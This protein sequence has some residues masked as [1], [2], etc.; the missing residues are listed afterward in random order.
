ML[1][2]LETNEQSFFWSRMT[3]FV[4]QIEF[5]CNVHQS[6]HMTIFVTINGNRFG[7]S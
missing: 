2:L 1:G 4:D 5:V 3:S 6:P 7:H